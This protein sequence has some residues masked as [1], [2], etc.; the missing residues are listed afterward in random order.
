M[1]TIDEAIAILQAM[2]EGKVVQAYSS[3][4]EEWLETDGH[5]PNFSSLTY[6][7]KPE[8]LECWVNVHNNGSV[9]GYQTKESAKLARPLFPTIARIAVHMREVESSG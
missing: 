8:P 3:A 7:I 9:S 1:N 2:K 5:I 6:R 4:S